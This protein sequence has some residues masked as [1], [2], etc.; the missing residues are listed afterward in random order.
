MARAT[1]SRVIG[2]LLLLAVLGFAWNADLIPQGESPAD[3]SR[4]GTWA[5]SNKQFFGTAYESYDDQ[6]KYSD[7]SPS[8]PLSKTW[9]TGAQGVLTEVF[10][11]TLDNPQTRDTQFLVTDGKS[12]FFEERKDS[13]TTVKWIQTGVPGFHIVN[14]DKQNRFEIERWVVSDPDRQVV[15]QKIRI[16]RF[17]AGLRFYLHHNPAAG[18]SPMGDTAWASVGKAPGAGMM[19]WQGGEAQ[20]LVSTVRWRQISAGFENTASDGFIDLQDFAFDSNFEWAKKGNVV[21]TGWLDVPEQAGETELT[22]AL[23]FGTSI[24]SAYAEAA[25]SLQSGFTPTKDRF[26]SQ[27]LDYQAKIANLEKQASDGGVLFRASVALMKAME[28]KSYAGAFVAS[29][30]IPWG[31]YTLDSHGGPD[32]GEPK[33][34]M[35]GGYHLV[36][37]RDLYHMATSFLAVGDTAS[38]TTSLNY[39]REVQLRAHHGVWKFGKRER[40]R[41]GSFFQNTWLDGTQHWPGVQQ[42][43]VGMPIILAYRLW[44]A[45]Q[46]ELSQYWSMIS[47]AGDFIVDFGPWTNQERW[48]DAFGVAPHAVA[49]QIAALWTGAEM[50]RAVGDNQRAIRFQMV[51]DEWHAKPGNNVEAWTYTTTG[52]LGNGK[53]YV[54]IEAAARYDQKIDPNDNE[55]YELANGGGLVLEKNVT[56]GGFL[57]LVR[58]GVRAANDTYVRES[59]GEYDSTIRRELPGFGPGFFRYLGDRYGYDEADGTQTAGMIWPIFTGERGHYELARAEEEKKTYGERQATIDPYIVAT[60][61]FATPSLMLPEQVWDK[62][63]RMG[64]PTGAATPLGWAHG[65]YVKLLRSR[66]DGKAFDRLPSVMDRAAAIPRP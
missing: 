46:I 8:A 43:E 48:E 64:R 38:A 22:L 58:F 5:S 62:G 1:A 23:G 26:A 34:K 51:G 47:R 56:D 10:W 18:N 40:S 13:V 2:I 44:K 27:W 17:Q 33:Q 29:P 35:M 9:F 53:Y 49:V 19:A 4:S 25:A 7:R 11:P 28:D 57:E 63:P 59:I 61:A 42:D 37:P 6:L 36:W 39:L 14:R 20:A 52:G 12:F 65:E 30:V 21:L 16:K 3:P 24:E 32:S 41:D 45:G 54:R 31:E 55:K 66:L 15:L 60:E 50:A